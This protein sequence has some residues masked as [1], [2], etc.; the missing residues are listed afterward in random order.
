M[1]ITGSP[2]DESHVVNSAEII[3][4]ILTNRCLPQKQPFT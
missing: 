4:K 3:H 2:Q 1:S